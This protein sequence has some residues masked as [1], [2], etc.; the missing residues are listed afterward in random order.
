MKLV[1]RRLVLREFREE[2]RGSL[3]AIQENPRFLELYPPGCTGRHTLRDLLR[4][5]VGWSAEQP[6]RGYRFAI[7]VR[8]EAD[9]VIGTCGIRLPTS[10]ASVAEFG[11]ALDPQRWG[12]GSAEEAARAIV[13]YGF[14]RLGRRVVQ[15]RS[16]SANC[17]A[18][19]AMRR[20]GFAER[21]TAPGEEWMAD[22]GWVD[23][24][25]ELRKAA[26]ASP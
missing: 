25:W 8:A 24:H 18:R 2:D 13:E 5:F 21:G 4:A 17:R 10:G 12:A 22:P 26:W 19:H 7:G 3:I 16:V 14:H 1:T 23:Q 11:I 9:R 6:R 20:F 15:A